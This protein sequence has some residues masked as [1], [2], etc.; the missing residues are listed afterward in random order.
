M[1]R[2]ST[3]R[4]GRRRRGPHGVTARDRPKSAISTASSDSADSAAT[5]TVA[6]A[7][8]LRRQS[9]DSATWLEAL[10]PIPGPAPATITGYV[11]TTY[12]AD[13][14]ITATPATSP[15]PDP[16][17]PCPNSWA[18]IPNLTSQEQF[19]IGDW[20]EAVH[21]QERQQ[22]QQQQQTISSSSGSRRLEALAASAAA[23]AKAPQCQAKPSQAVPSAPIIPLPTLQHTQTRIDAPYA[24]AWCGES[25]K[26]QGA[27]EGAK[28]AG[29]DL[30]P[31]TVREGTRAASARTA[32]N[33]RFV[34]ECP[35]GREFELEPQPWHKP[36][37]IGHSSGS[38]CNAHSQYHNHNHK[39]ND[40]IHQHTN[41]D[42]KHK[43]DNYNYVGSQTTMPVNSNVNSGPFATEARPRRG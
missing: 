21:T 24:D 33:K 42:I 15:I 19:Q 35:F 17:L 30:V 6:N 26:Q 18:A 40:D 38:K 20:V 14:T 41:S 29:N 13:T 3:A 27:R 11:R 37:S 22:Q 31:A 39:Y 36:R 34:F 28:R 12:H 1:P 43:N 5:G 32:A 23:S 16:D 10:P 2:G 9:T 4:R 8:I 25:R 7:A